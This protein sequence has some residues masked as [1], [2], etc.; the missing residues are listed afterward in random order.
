MGF[1][2]L[3]TVVRSTAP[4]Q[5]LLRCVNV[6][7]VMRAGCSN[8]INIIRKMCAYFLHP[9]LLCA[10][11]AP[12]VCVRVRARLVDVCRTM[13]VCVC[14]VRVC[15]L[16]VCVFRACVCGACVRVCCACVSCTRLWCVFVCECVVHVCVVC[17]CVCVRVCV[18]CV[19]VM[20]FLRYVP[21]FRRSLSAFILPANLALTCHLTPHRNPFLYQQCRLPG[22]REIAWCDTMPELHVCGFL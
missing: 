12:C 8:S 6:L 13:R 20:V 18:L 5:Q 21:C 4:Q 9:F 10:T 11:L 7:A 1:F 16:C 15:V 2:M 19:C 22:G 3:H 17:V 14:V